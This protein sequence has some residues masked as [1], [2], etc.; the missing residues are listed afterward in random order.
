MIVGQLAMF[1]LLYIGMVAVA[2]RGGAIYGIYFYPRVVQERAVTIGLTDWATIRRRKRRFMSGFC[3]VLLVALVLV[4]GGWNRAIDFQTA[5][6]Q[7]LLFLEVMNWFDGIVIDRLW[8]GHSKFW[9]IPGTEDLPFVQS[10]GQMV[11]KRAVLSV[12]WLAGAAIVAGIVV[13]IF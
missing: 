9:L 11:K 3:V 1:C 2:V 7:S 13:A 6:W 5:Y 10:W 12:V 8:V 4:I